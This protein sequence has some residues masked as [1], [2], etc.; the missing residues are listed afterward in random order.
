MMLYPARWRRIGS[1]ILCAACFLWSGVAASADATINPGEWKM[2]MKTQIKGLGI[3]LPSIPVSFTSCITQTNPVAESPEMKK[4]GCRIIDPKID[5][6][7]VTYT[8]RCASGGSITDTHYKLTYTGDE[9]SGTY[10]QVRTVG[11]ESR[12]TATGTI[13]G[14][15][16]GACKN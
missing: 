11:S 9:M 12:S 2:T 1:N 5:G 13:S 10:D 8:G 14:K 7:R 3:P 16:L 6:P 4:A 15:R